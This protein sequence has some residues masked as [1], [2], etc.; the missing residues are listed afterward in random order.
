MIVSQAAAAAA[1]KQRWRRLLCLAL[2]PNEALGWPGSRRH[3]AVDAATA[4]QQQAQGRA[5]GAGRDS[6]SGSASSSGSAADIEMGVGHARDQ[7]A[8]AGGGGGGGAGAEADAHHETGSISSR[9][10]LLQD[11]QQPSSSSASQP[12]GGQ[13]S[14]PG[15]AGRVLQRG[16]GGRSSAAGWKPPR[17]DML[18]LDLP[19]VY[20]WPKLLLWLLFEGVLVTLAVQDSLHAN[21]SEC[22]ARC[23][24]PSAWVG[25]REAGWAGASCAV[26]QACR[27]LCQTRGRAACVGANR[28]PAGRC[29]ALTDTCDLHSCWPSPLVRRAAAH[30][31]M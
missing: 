17:P 8:R 22:G 2:E 7:L 4:G 24:L 28:P 9:A 12:R 21:E 6:G 26:P 27:V 5:A 20:H 14:A 10:G 11:A 23:V 19:W 31:C 13:H 1:A 3:G 15:A 29:R 16:K 25:A 30:A 18:V